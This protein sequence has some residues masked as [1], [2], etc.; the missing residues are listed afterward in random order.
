MSRYKSDIYIYFM[1]ESRARYSI[2]LNP[3]G[4][5]LNF[6]F[7][8]SKKYKQLTDKSVFPRKKGNSMSEKTVHAYNGTFCWPLFVAVALHTSFLKMKYARKRTSEA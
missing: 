2:N 4:M 8:I 5:R 3:L 7:I 1:N 6:F